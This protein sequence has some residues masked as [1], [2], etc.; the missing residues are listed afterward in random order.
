[1]IVED[2][3]LIA[4]DVRDSLERMGY[5]VDAV[6]P[7]GE[8]AVEMAAVSRPDVILMD[9]VL[10]DEMDGVTAAE[11][12]R[13]RCS[14]P[15]VFLTSYAED[16][17]FERAKHAGPYGYVI[18]PFDDRDLRTTIEM[19]LYRHQIEQERESLIAELREAVRE[20]Q[21]VESEVLKLSHAMEQTGSTVIITDTRGKIEY[22]N[23][24]FT[25]ITGYT[26]EEAVGQTP[27]L[28]KSG[29]QDE[30]VFDELWQT[31]SS[32]REWRGE[33]CNRSKSGELYW[34]LASISPVRSPDGETVHYVA[35]MEEITDRKR[36]EEELRQAK[37]AADA[38][39][40]AKSAFLASMS[41][42]IRTP[43]NGIVGMIE[44][45]LGTEL[46]DEQKE[47]LNMARTSADA[48]MA[49]LGDIL[50]FSKI[51]AGK[52]ELE[53]IKFRLGSCVGDLVKSVALHGHQKGLEVG[54][55]VDPD[56][57]DHLVGDPGRLRQVLINLLGNAIKFTEQ[58][59]V[60]VRVSREDGGDH[61]EVILHFAV[62]DT[63]IGISEEQQR[64]IFSA[65]AQVDSSMSR[66][67]GGT[68]LGLAIARQLVELMGGRIWVESNVGQGCVFH[69]TARYRVHLAS[70][71]R[72]ARAEPDT[73]LGLPVLIV[74]DSASSREMLIEQIS[75]WGMCPTAVAGANE[76]LVEVEQIL[77]EKRR[78]SL[79]LVDASMP[80]M[81]GFILAQRFRQHQELADTKIIMLTVTGRPGDAAR[82]RELNLNGYLT[83]PINPSELLEAIS[84]VMGVAADQIEKPLVTRHTL[85]EGRAGLRVLLAEDHP[86]NQVLTASLL[87]REGFEVAVA[88]NGK[89]AIEALGESSFDLVLMDVQM[90]VMDGIEATIKIREME[91]STDSHLPI[92]AITAHA[93]K[94]DREQFLAAGMDAYVAKPIR[95]EALFETINEV[96]TRAGEEHQTEQTNQGGA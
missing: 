40:L 35:V 4:D 29:V 68:G 55:R 46:A 67:K 76:A 79:I 47:Y 8:E 10:R 44:L 11:A 19:A 31:V 27:R 36:A 78:L 45:V 87:E 73:L 38:A 71:D 1:M 17:I 41:H 86:V 90:P 54:W 28:L 39:S 25:A 75:H 56:V 21:R 60:Q 3:S 72:T 50:D 84:T 6:Y 2:E 61:Q 77:A 20:R 66:S 18:K 26:R 51:E 94:G 93:L 14:I 58:G 62:S 43:I 16:E 59:E 37:E 88:G 92:I 34:A 91:Q 74:D 30:K 95:P 64:D 23:P 32:G 48:L 53:R 65:F 83:K 22:V 89:E 9:I 12:I 15:V 13:E 33:L 70:L 82:C 96:L 69:F 7:S 57:P 85:R 80:E 24:K 63:G 52:L 42:E 49:L 5:D 81:D